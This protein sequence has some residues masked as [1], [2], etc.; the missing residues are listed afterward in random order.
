MI[1]ITFV[2]ILLQWQVVA[3]NLRT[4]LILLLRQHLVRVFLCNNWFLLKD[5]F[6]ST[7]FE[8]LKK[9]LT[10]I[11]DSYFH[12]LNSLLLIVRYLTFSFLIRLFIFLTFFKNLNAWIISY[13]IPMILHYFNAVIDITQSW[14]INFL[15]L[16]IYH[17]NL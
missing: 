14:M 8:L 4:L 1:K 10:S 16:M 11:G 9:V 13:I 12:L 6:L 17:W 3:T 15:V 7:C 5:G 2:L